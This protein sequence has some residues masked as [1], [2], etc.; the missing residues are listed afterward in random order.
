M[1]IV[2]ILVRVQEI[3]ANSDDPEMAHGQED[4]LHQDALHAIAEG[5][6]EETA[7]DLARAALQTLEIKFSRWYE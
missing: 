2:D 7:A 4:D 1:N 3:R 5:N 6:Y